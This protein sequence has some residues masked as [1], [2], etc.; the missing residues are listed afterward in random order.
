M[1]TGWDTCASPDPGGYTFIELVVVMALISVMFFLA[2]PRLQDNLL[3]DPV[4]KTSR[5]VITQTRLLKQQA[6][7]NRK[8]YVLQVDVDADK[9]WVVTPE[10]EDEQLEKA[11]EGAFQLSSDVDIVDVEFPVSGKISSGQVGIRFYAAGYSDKA[12]IH[13]EHDNDRQFS[14]LI[15]SFLPQTRYVEEYSDFEN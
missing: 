7:R 13:M 1:T 4:G 10:M 3:A 5:W 12:L 15:E 8:D 14:F 11:E 6:I 9:L 2:M